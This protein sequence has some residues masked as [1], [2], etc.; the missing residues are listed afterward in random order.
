MSQKKKLLIF[1]D[2]YEKQVNGVQI[3]LRELTKHLSEELEISIISADRFST[4]P[5]PTYREVRI[6]VVTP[7]HIM[8]IIKKEKPD[9]I[10]IATEAT[11]GFSAAR[12]CK[13]L[14]LPYTSAFHTKIPEYIHLRIPFI[15][16]EWV[17]KTLQYIHDGSAR[18]FVSNENMKH[19]LLDHG[20]ARDQICVL[21][22]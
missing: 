7:R 17:H 3:S 16:E 22:F 6:S 13:K 10:H 20:Y 21:P 15:Q 4:I 11:V 9:S 14:S 18:I 8:Q 2:T 5:C 19:Y 12:A 1:T